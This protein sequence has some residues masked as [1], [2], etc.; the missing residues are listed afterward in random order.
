MGKGRGW[1]GAKVW[2]EG[3]GRGLGG[4]GT[5]ITSSSSMGSRPP[6][7]EDEA[8]VED[9]DEED[10][11]E[12]VALRPGDMTAIALLNPAAAPAKIPVG[13]CCARAT[14]FT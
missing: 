14:A 11:D 1:G 7:A 12:L 5:S 3:W 4:A 2:G 6:S 8:R 10:E 9:E 13:C